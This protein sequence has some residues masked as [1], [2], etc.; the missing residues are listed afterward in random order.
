MPVRP[1]RVKTL[2]NCRAPPR[3]HRTLPNRRPI[4]RPCAPAAA[5]PFSFRMDDGPRLAAAPPCCT[6]GQRPS[7]PPPSLVHVSTVADTEG[8]LL[9]SI[10]VPCR[11][12]RIALPRGIGQQPWLIGSSLP[13]RRPARQP[14]ATPRLRR[15]T[16]HRDVLLPFWCGWLPLGFSAASLS[17]E[18][19]RFIRQRP[20]V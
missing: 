15:G 2:G 12:N 6:K 16:K 14:A 8:F 10:L 20:A 5:F 11:W 18:R 13:P 19:N 9:T 1:R 17:S 4:T 7:E 3:P